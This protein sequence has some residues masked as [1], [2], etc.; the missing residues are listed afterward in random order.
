[1]ARFSAVVLAV[2]S[3]AGSAGAGLHT[4]T[5]AD[6]AWLIIVDDLHVPFVHTG[7]LRDLL[8][9]VAAE[10]IQEGDRSVFRATGPSA[11]S[12]TTTT[13]VDDRTLAAHAIK[14]MTG[15]ALKE[16]DIVLG[17]FTTSP[18]NEVLY[19]ANTALDAAEDAMFALTTDAAPRQAIVYVGSGYDIEAFP[20]IG[21]R[22]R[23]F[24]RRAR[25]NNITIF[26]IDARGLEPLPIPNSSDAW[27]RYAAAARRSL[28][29]MTEVAGGFVIE[30]P[31]RPGALDGIGAQM[32]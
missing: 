17:G 23:A 14:F 4:S 11:S 8:R 21:D 24:A 27:L 6:N 12:L 9:K 7:R 3:C 22:V 10:L 18:T 1:M 19:R 29:S 30:N 25:E 5:A 16:S 20:A 26:A 13:L 2:L 15:N 28:A 31:A 32:R